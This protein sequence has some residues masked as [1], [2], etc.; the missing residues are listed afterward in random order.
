M[1]ALRPLYL[2]PEL[3]IEIAKHLDACSLLCVSKVSHF[4][5][6]IALSF[7]DKISLAGALSA[8]RTAKV[9]ANHEA[10]IYFASRIRRNER[11]GP[12][13]GCLALTW[14][15]MTT[16]S[17]AVRILIPFASMPYGHQRSAQDVNP[18]DEPLFEA[19]RQHN[20][21]ALEALLQNGAPPDRIDYFGLNA[22]CMPDG[23]GGDHDH[24]HPTLESPAPGIHAAIVRGFPA[25]LKYLLNQLRDD[26]RQLDAV[27]NEDHNSDPALSVAAQVGCPDILRILLDHNT[28]VNQ[29]GP[30]LFTP[31]AIAAYWG[32]GGTREDT[33]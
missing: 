18:W 15:C 30:S 27:L 24:D 5:R 11:T 9:N 12:P 22:G 14:A 10:L 17:E 7:L 4:W 28:D 31:L 20:P 25:A 23:G 6:E 16:C 21:E 33:T 13:T 19:M 8:F 1:A 2:P 26:P 32:W 29:P 3:A